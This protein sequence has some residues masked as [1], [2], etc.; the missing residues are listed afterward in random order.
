MQPG[1][2]PVKMWDHVET[3]N[4]VEIRVWVHYMPRTKA[5]NESSLVTG[6]C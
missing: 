3:N 1:T 6:F 5:A 4:G 2:S